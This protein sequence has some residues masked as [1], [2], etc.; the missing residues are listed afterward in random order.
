[1]K[2]LLI[3][4]IILLMLILTGFTI[5]KG[6]D[7]GPLKVLGILEIKDENDK[8]DDKVKQAT[9]L[10]S[11]DYQKKIDD[12]NTAIKQLETQKNSYEDMVNVS[13]DSQVE[14]ANQT[15]N[16]TID[17]LFV[18]IENHAKSEGVTMKMEVTRS[19]TGVNNVYN[20]NFTATGSY[21]GIEEFITGIEDD[22][23]L[24]FKIEDF[25]MTATSGSNG[26]QVEATFVCKNIIIK[27]IENT[28]AS[29][30]SMSG[31]TKIDSS[32]DNT[33]STNTTDNTT[34]DNTVSGNTTNS[35][36]KA[37]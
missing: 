19:S 2:K 30:G 11:T 14:A 5:V 34:T 8:L 16:N 12:L 3:S 23:K 33:N 20:L 6:I 13:T 27:G 31:T 21:T 1:M 29:S 7:I 4:I 36:N 25:S 18:R 28:S 22:S 10:T 37:Q 17:F 24:G 35:V 32:T 9:K 15:Y 26:E